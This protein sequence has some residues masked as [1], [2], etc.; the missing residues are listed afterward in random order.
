MYTTLSQSDFTDAFQKLRPDNFSY[1]G[2]HALFD[3]LEEYEKDV[4]ED[5]E[6]DVISLCCAFTEYES[7]T[8]AC[9]EV[10]SLERGEETDDEEH[11]KACLEW[12]RDN[13]LCLEIEG[14]G[15]IVS[16]H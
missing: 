3:F 2:L 9:A 4:G 11:E 14:G 10:S 1:F 8:E 5:S 7:A 13:G 6:L 15:I 16:G 12:L